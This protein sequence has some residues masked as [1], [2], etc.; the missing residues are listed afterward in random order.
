MSH[1]A[2][3]EALDRVMRDLRNSEC[4]MGGFTILFL[5]D[6]RQILPVMTRGTRADEVNA[7]LKRSY[8]WPHITKCD[9]KTNMRIVSFLKD[10]RQFS[11]D[12]LQICNGVNDFITLNNLCILVKNVEEL[13]EKVNPLRH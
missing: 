8:L 11:T 7:S 12:L 4:P 5:G 6:F 13:T 1:K 3:V 10:N 9:L 2:S